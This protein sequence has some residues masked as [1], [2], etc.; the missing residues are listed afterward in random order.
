MHRLPRL[1]LHYIHLYVC[2]IEE[3]VMAYGATLTTSRSTTVRYLMLPPVV[4]PPAPTITTQPNRTTILNMSTTAAASDHET[5]VFQLTTTYVAIMEYAAATL[6]VVAAP[7]HS[8]F[9]LQC[10]DFAGVATERPLEF[11]PTAIVNLKSKRRDSYVAMQVRSSAVAGFIVPENGFDPQ[12]VTTL[13]SEPVV[14]IKGTM[15]RDAI[16]LFGSFV[17][18]LV[19]RHLRLLS[20]NRA[21][22]TT[23]VTLTRSLS[24]TGEFQFQQHPSSTKGRHGDAVADDD[25]SAHGTAEDGTTT[26]ADDRSSLDKRTARALLYSPLDDI[27]A[28]PPPPP[29]AADVAACP[30]APAVPLL[31]EP[32]GISPIRNR[33]VPVPRAASPVTKGLR[34]VAREASLLVASQPDDFHLPRRRAPA[35]TLP[36][37]APM[38]P[39][40]VP[41]VD[42]LP[43]TPRAPGATSAAAMASA[44]KQ[45][46]STKQPTSMKRPPAPA[47][48]AATVPRTSRTCREDVDED[49]AKPLGSILAGRVGSHAKEPSSGVRTTARRTTARTLDDIFDVSPNH[50]A[51]T[52]GSDAAKTSSSSRRQPAKKRPLS[53]IQPA[54]PPT[55][56]VTTTA[57]LP[58]KHHTLKHQVAAA[59]ADE[60]LIA[61]PTPHTWLHAAD[62]VVAEPT[63]PLPSVTAKPQAPADGTGRSARRGGAAVLGEKSLNLSETTTIKKS[64]RPLPGPPASM[65]PPPPPPPTAIMASK[66][67]PLLAGIPTPPYR[68]GRDQPSVVRA[69][70][71]ARPSGRR[72]TSPADNYAPEGDDTRLI[73]LSLQ[74]CEDFE[75]EDVAAM[76]RLME[77][78]RRR[79]QE[80]R[81]IEASERAAHVCDRLVGECF[82]AAKRHRTECMHTLTATIH[83]LG[84]RSR[85]LRANADELDAAAQGLAS[86]LQQ[87]LYSAD[88]RDASLEAAAKAALT[89][90]LGLAT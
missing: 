13:L 64:G 21:Y 74:R 25:A 4:Q 52:M 27:G 38:A 7:G 31:R 42:D 17:V 37:Q 16:A 11:P 5:V 51:S 18:P 14:E 82:V 46:A 24:R 83:D 3:Y 19:Q 55:S 62:D 48:Q 23:T 36:E 59:E 66:A 86:V 67:S 77:A 78:K 45:L 84:N 60:V 39:K 69:A 87:A 41:A 2:P 12:D 50:T 72:G 85:Q 75:G 30:A 6:T 57:Q 90:K 71:S 63:D 76:L 43:P 56:S 54:V 49:D 58:A 53:A 79:A 88:A 81:R 68:S 44:Q 15:S 9:R 10:V 47:S 33:A 40:P 1:V 70:P 89:R 65:P 32:D 80:A 26:T 35:A 28:T 22:S 8:V 73:A 34:S 20:T 61:T 29:A